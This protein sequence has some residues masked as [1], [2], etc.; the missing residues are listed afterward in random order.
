MISSA[1]K[2]WQEDMVWVVKTPYLAA[3]QGETCPVWGDVV[4]Y[5]SVT[6]VVPRKDEADAEYCLA[7]HHGGHWSRRKDLGRGFI[8]I[9]S[10][11]QCW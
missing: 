2:R 10:D 7:C 3:A 5:K 1:Q 11:Y 6:V 9:R 4:P 8:A